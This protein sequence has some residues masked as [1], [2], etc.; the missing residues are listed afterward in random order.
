M[1]LSDDFYLNIWVSDL[2]GFKFGHYKTWSSDFYF[3]YPH[4][5]S[6]NSSLNM[7]V[8]LIASLSFKKPDHRQFWPFPNDLTNQSSDL[9]L[10]LKSSD[11]FFVKWIIRNPN[12]H[13]NM[14]PFLSEAVE[15]NL[16]YL[17]E[18]W[19]MKL[20]FPDL[21]NIQIPSSKI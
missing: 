16:R 15:A 11:C 12:F 7:N 17:F 18:N 8:L 5:T 21:R 4:S 2:Y 10:G 14:A 6:K 20:K 13:R 1:I 19:L 3:S 9:Q